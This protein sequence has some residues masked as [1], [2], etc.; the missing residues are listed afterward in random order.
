MGYP[1]TWLRSDRRQLACP[2]TRLAHRHQGL[3]STRY[4]CSPSSPRG[5][6]TSSAMFALTSTCR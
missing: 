5:C 2:T 3:D 1:T 6:Q 4:R